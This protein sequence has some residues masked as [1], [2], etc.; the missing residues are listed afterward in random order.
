M[1]WSSSRADMGKQHVAY[2]IRS[3]IIV[4]AAC[5]HA[6]RGSVRVW[7]SIIYEFTYCTAGSVGWHGVRRAAWYEHLRQRLRSACRQAS[8]RWT[9]ARSSARGTNLGREP[10]LWSGATSS[11]RRRGQPPS[12]RLEICAP[13]AFQIDPCQQP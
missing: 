12:S 11:R 4:C 2:S 5:E 13:A 7:H 1:T 10:C 6:A 3:I 8:P 9:R